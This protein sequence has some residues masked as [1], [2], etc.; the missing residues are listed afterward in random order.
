MSAMKSTVTQLGLLAALALGACGTSPP[1]Q[2]YQL[3]ADPPGYSPAQALAATTNA[4][5]WGLGPV[6]LPEYLDRDAIVR[7]SGQASLL[8]NPG[9]RWAEALRDAVPRLLQQ[10]LARLRGG[11]SVWRMPLPPGVAAARQLRVE[12]QRLDAESGGRS[13]V[14]QARWTLIDTSGASRPQVAERR[15]EVAVTG[16]DTDALV[17]AHRSALW[18]LA[19]AIA[20]QP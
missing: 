2:L 10:D 5:T 19:Q 8:T 17:S 14:L 6:L 16:P 3:R 4:A 12:I 7:A 20:G 13:V 11:E 18:Q 9:E 15:I 1:V